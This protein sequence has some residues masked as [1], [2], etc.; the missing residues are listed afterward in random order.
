MRRVCVLIAAAALCFVA[1]SGCK[2]EPGIKSLEPAKGNVAGGDDV[3]IM[4]AGF[5]RGMT[6]HFGKKRVANVVVEAATKIRVKSP[7][8]KAG[9]VDIILTDE[10]GQTMVLKNGFTYTS[11]NK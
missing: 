10:T 7:P 5:K 6:V 8:N 2:S 3:I 11:Q 9:A 1:L 4:G